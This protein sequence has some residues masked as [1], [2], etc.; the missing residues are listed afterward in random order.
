MNEENNNLSD[1]S[2]TLN[3]IMEGKDG[4]LIGRLIR[5]KN[6]VKDTKEG[7][8]T[9]CYLGMLNKYNE[10]VRVHLA[11]RMALNNEKILKKN[12]CYYIRGFDLVSIKNS[13]KQIRLKDKEYKIS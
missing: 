2:L 6:I 11:G 13:G 10:L 3:D 9:V 5:F 12:K 7:P 4:Y 1:S 8:M